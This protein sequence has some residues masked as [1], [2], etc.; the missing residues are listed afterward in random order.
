MQ[1]VL[2]R[3]QVSM[4]YQGWEGL[5]S[6]ILVRIAQVEVEQ[7]TTET[8]AA[9]DADLQHAQVVSLRHA[10]S[11]DNE[12]T[13]STRRHPAQLHIMQ[14]HLGRNLFAIEPYQLGV[15]VGQRKKSAW[16]SATLQHNP[17]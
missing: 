13:T 1:E 17:A 12:S 10:M 6:S 8:L 5:C 2:Q 4:A 3:T 7:A 16:G 11:D 9:K 14:P 15:V